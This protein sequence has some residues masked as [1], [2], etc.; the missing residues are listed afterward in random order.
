MAGANCAVVLMAKDVVNIWS[1]RVFYGVLFPLSWI[2]LLFLLWLRRQ[3][4]LSTSTCRP[5]IRFA[6][7]GCSHDWKLQRAKLLKH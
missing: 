7:G 2:L 4:W 5:H 3:V 1:L 6:I